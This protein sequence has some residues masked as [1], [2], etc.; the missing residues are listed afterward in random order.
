[1]LI[2]R[3]GKSAERKVIPARGKALIDTQLFVAVP[4]GTYGRVAPRSGLGR[5]A[6]RFMLDTDAGV[7]DSDRRGV[8]FVLLFNHPDSDFHGTWR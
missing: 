1:M 8:L 3:G 2:F 6:S 5:L 7:I 4:S